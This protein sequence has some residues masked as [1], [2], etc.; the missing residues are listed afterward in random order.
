MNSNENSDDIISEV[1]DDLFQFFNCPLFK[2]QYI[3][4]L[5]G[6]NLKSWVENEKKGYWENIEKMNIVWT[7]GCSLNAHLCDSDIRDEMV[8][9][10]GRYPSLEN[11]TAEEKTFFYW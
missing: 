11:M 7:K 2:K 1:V 4:S 9:I 3:E 5:I 6:S 8:K 10:Y